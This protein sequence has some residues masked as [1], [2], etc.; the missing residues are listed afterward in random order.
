MPIAVGEPLSLEEVVAVARG[1]EVELAAAAAAR[2]RA[3]REVI[4]AAVA[5]GDTVY[6]V[7]TGFGSLADVRIDPAQAD[8]LQHRI[9]RSHATAVG[10]PLGREEVRGRNRF[11]IDEQVTAA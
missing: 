6:G 11:P 1:A 5:S 9:V 10:R 2:M 4:D 3:A 8:A 7:T